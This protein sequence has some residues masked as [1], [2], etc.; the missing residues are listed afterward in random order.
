VVTSE[1][2]RVERVDNIVTVTLDRPGKKNAC[3]MDMW[4]AIRDAFRDIAM[5]TARVVILT[6]ANG[7]FCAG[8]DL[9]NSLGGDS[10]VDAANDSSGGFS[11]GGLAGMR[12]LATVVSAVHD[13]PVPVIAK[14]DGVA[15]GAGFGLALAAD[16]LW[17]SERARFSLAFVRLGLSL[18]FGTSWVLPRRMGL[19]QAKRLAY[20][21]DIIDAARAERLGFVN[22]V[23]SVEALDA[24][25]AAI[26]TQIAGGPPI[27]LSMTK[28]MLDNAANASLVQATEAETVAQGVNLATTDLRDALQAFA[29]KRRPEF[30][31]R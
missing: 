20:T 15:I 26:A 28:R 10:S 5:S 6:G 3:T 25:V 31:G 17:C 18:D 21:G 2:I 8:A 11:R 7:D 30:Q 14:V 29:E 23:V 27:A 1:H 9:G 16:M 22:E 24:D 12:D 4:L 19:H 13:C